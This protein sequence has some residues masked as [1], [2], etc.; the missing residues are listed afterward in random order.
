MSI[1]VRS[2]GRAALAPTILQRHCAI[3]RDGSVE[4]DLPDLSGIRV[5]AVDDQPDAREMV[6]AVLEQFDANVMTVGSAEEALEAFPAW[7]PDVLLCD[8]GMPA[9]DGLTLIRRVRKLETKEGRN[10]PAIA[11]TAYARVEDRMRWARR[12]ISDVQCRK[13]VEAG[14]LGITIARSDRASRWRGAHMRTNLSYW[15][16]RRFTGLGALGIGQERPRGRQGSASLTPSRA[17][18][19][20]PNVE[21]IHMNRRRSIAGDGRR[22]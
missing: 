21:I 8:I 1:P 18:S 12:R 15:G 9:E 13:P 10:T 17:I 16:R 14:E 20:V 11:L 3:A 19:W 2:A 22:A 7:K 5:L 4:S 6:R